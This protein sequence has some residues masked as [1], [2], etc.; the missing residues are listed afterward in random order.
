V[1]G[2]LLDTNVVSELRKGDRTNP[3]LAARYQERDKRELY[4][5]VI[6]LA[7]LRRGIALI[8]HRDPRQ[9]E[10]L[11]QW[12]RTPQRGFSRAG[13]LLTLRHG[14]RL[15]PDAADRDPAQVA[16]A[17]AEQF[18]QREARDSQ[19]LAQILDFA[20]ASGCI[21]RRLLGY[22]GEPLADENC[23]HCHC[24]RT[25]EPATAVVLPA[26]PIPPFTKEDAEEI[27]A[28]IF[29]EIPSLATLRAVTRLLCG[30]TSP[31]TTRAKLTKRPEFARHSTV[32]F[33]IVLAQV[34]ACWEEN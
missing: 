14:Y 28:L 2:Y 15:S 6:T 8:G 7:E 26:T 19:R 29:E 18:A 3:G 11:D 34:E 17:L 1:R 23:G 20:S 21:T 22:F 9:A 16:A 33:R 32:P 13:H 25:G 30:L 10:S 5:S 4:L 27:R 12:C 31:A 24:C